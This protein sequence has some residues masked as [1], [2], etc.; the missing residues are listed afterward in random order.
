MLIVYEYIQALN[1][2]TPRE[3]YDRAFRMKRASQASVL[4]APL[5]KEEWIPASEVRFHVVH[6]HGRIVQLAF[7]RMS[8]IWHPTSKKC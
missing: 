1:R 4:H 8:A 5:A 6:A 7:Y 2:L 3:Q